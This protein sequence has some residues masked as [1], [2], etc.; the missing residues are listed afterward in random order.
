LQYQEI[1]SGTKLYLIYLLCLNFASGSSNFVVVA[2][3]L[4]VQAVTQDHAL[5]VV[6]RLVSCNLEQILSLSLYLM[7][8]IQL[9]RIGIYECKNSDHTEPTSSEKDREKCSLRISGQV[10]QLQEFDL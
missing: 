4:L 6:L 9:K 5:Q 3:P 2:F 1:N 10:L 7:T 8:L